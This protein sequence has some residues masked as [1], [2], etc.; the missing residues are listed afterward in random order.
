MLH[1]DQ[2]ENSLA[3]KDPGVLAGSNLTISQ[4]RALAAERANGILGCI[5]RTVANRLR[6]MIFQLY[7]ALVRSQLGVLCPVLG[8][9]V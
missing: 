4:Q 9:S 2:L 5:R 3:K 6:E 7:I 8:S 1:T